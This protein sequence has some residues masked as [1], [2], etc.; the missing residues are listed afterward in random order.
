MVS[1]MSAA[2]NLMHISIRSSACQSILLIQPSLASAE[3]AFSLL[4]NSFREDLWKTILNYQYYVT[5][6]T[7]NNTLLHMDDFIFDNYVRIMGNY[8]RILLEEL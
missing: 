5:V 8:F 1:L 6:H 4:T 3:R 7:I 2:V